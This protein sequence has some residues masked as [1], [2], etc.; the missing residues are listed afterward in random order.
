M[1]PR[2]CG[3]SAFCVQ[4]LVAGSYCV[5]GLDRDAG[6]DQA[7]DQVDLAVHAGRPGWS[8]D[9][10]GYGAAADQILVPGS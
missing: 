9:L 1:A 7:A 6:V 5:D 3:R 2:G 4:V 8:T 10:P